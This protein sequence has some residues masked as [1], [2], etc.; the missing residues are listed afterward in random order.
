MFGDLSSKK[1]LRWDKTKV[2]EAK[3]CVR[4]RNKKKEK[5]NKDNHEHLDLP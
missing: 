3:G 5:R 4:K 1:L 2:K